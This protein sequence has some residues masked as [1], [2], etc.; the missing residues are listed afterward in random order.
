MIEVFTDRGS[1]QAIVIL[2]TVNA[3]SRIESAF[4]MCAAVAKLF[5]RSCMRTS[6][7]SARTRTIEVVP[8]FGKF[9]GNYTQ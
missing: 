4:L 2:P 6:F 5:Q 3:D 9:L 7:R 1:N 8:L